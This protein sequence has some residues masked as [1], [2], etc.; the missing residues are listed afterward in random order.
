MLGR[1]LGVLRR[2]TMRIRSIGTTLAF[3]IVA[4]AAAMAANPQMG[5][6]KL[7]EAQSKLSG[8]ARNNLVVYTEAG[9]QVKVTIDGVDGTGKTYHSEWTGKFDGKE[10][11]VT[12]DSQSDA[13]SYKMVNDSTLSFETKKDGKVMLNGTV[14]VAAD[15]KSRTVTASGMNAKGEKVTETAVYDKQ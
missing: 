15:G 3:G 4:V 11:P 6:W 12:G 14:V 5:T 2:A 13:R 7:N 9:D 8:V 1:R 10:Y